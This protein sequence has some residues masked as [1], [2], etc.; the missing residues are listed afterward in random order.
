[1]KNRLVKLVSLV[2]ALAMALSTM[3]FA[4]GA[5]GYRIAG[6]YDPANNTID[7]EVYIQSVKAAAGRLALDFDESKVELAGDSSLTAAIKPAERILILNE[8]REDSALIS[9]QNGYICFAWAPNGGIWDGVSQDKLVATISFKLKDGVKTDDFDADTFRLM[10]VSD[11]APLNWTSGA[12]IFSENFT[13][14]ENGVSGRP[15]CKVSFSYPG[16]DIVPIYS[17]NVEIALCD[18]SGKPLNGKLIVGTQELEVGADGLAKTLKTQGRYNCRVIVDGFEEKVFAIDVKGDTKT[19]VELRTHQELVNDVA[20]SLA[21]GFAKGDSASHVTKDLTLLTA[22]ESGTKISWESKNQRVLSN[23]GNVFPDYAQTQASLVATVSIGG[24]TATKTFVVTIAA[25]GSAGDSETEEPAGEFTDLGSVP[26]A[27]EAI[28]A[29]SQAGIISGYEDNTFKPQ[30]NITRGDYMALIMRMLD[31]AG[32][33][34]QD[35]SDVPV[36]SYYY[37]EIT[38]AR[39]LGIAAGYEG[40][41]F[42]PRSRIS[43]QDMMTLTYRTLCTMGYLTE[44]DPRADLGGFADAKDIAGYAVQPMEALIQ[45]GYIKGNANNTLAPKSSATRAEAAVF[46]YTI[47]QDLNALK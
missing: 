46:L 34:G 43:R 19:A 5:V 4:D 44:T 26:W 23:Y 32:M 6:A 21:I 31:P 28:L 13:N 7:V 36:S 3:A 38:L 40:N 1:M 10:D 22:G 2:L 42:M 11:N 41:R 15:D 30:N 18:T 14:Y 27:E 9:S 16:S 33:P 12:W 39:G 8:G 37:N 45:K 29:L 25:K 20:K 47:Y 17:Y 35:F 24:K